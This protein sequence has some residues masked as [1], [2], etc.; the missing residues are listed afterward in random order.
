[1]KEAMVMATNAVLT[2]KELP[3]T[4]KKTFMSNEDF[5][6][7][8]NQQSVEDYNDQEESEKES[9]QRSVNSRS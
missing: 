8:L 6:K 3:A 9:E 5:E 7:Q 4:G 1:M 2:N